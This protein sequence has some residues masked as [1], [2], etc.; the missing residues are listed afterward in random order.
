[1]SKRFAFV[2]AVVVAFIAATAS[3]S[4][5]AP[6]PNRAA[7][8]ATTM[9]AR[10]P[11]NWPQFRG[12][13][14]LGIAEDTGVPTSWSESDNV[15]WKSII[16]GRGHSSPVVWG[17]R[18]FISSAIEG[19]VIPGASAPTHYIGGEVF[20]HPQ[21]MGSDRSH[22]LKVM[23]YSRGSGELLWSE[24]AYQGRM[25]DDRHQGASYASATA[26][27]DGDLVFFYFGS[28][29]V[30][31]Y[32]FDGE[33]VWQADLGDFSYF[34]VGLGTS[35][36]LFEDSLILQIDESNGD[37][38][39]IVGLDKRTGEEAWRT[40]RA[41][42]ASWATP[43][44]L[45]DV[46][47]QPQLLA[48]G[49]QLLIAYD[50]RSGEE[51]W[52]LDGLHNNAIHSPVWDGERVYV[53]AG[54]PRSVIQGIR[55][56]HDDAEVVWEYNKGAAYVASN[57][58]YDGYLY[59]TND[60]GIITCLDAA[61]GDVVYEGGRIP[62]PASMLMSSLLVVDGRIMMS[63][64]E[65]DTFFIATGP[66]FAVEGHNTLDNPILATPAIV[67]DTIYVRGRDHLY[68]IADAG[69]AP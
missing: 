57:V 3:R 25:Y 61:T 16:E 14:G 64:P 4:A 20:K 36:I 21:A 52:Q 48:I 47:G 5:S 38:S 40:P 19:E 54:Y 63:T 32:D 41:V 60:K 18:I 56:G 24:V 27:T 15:L 12:P 67:G 26:A 2:V 59:V 8:G 65:G 44:L 43:L 66:E 45:D 13:G 9:S 29:G 22:T 28:Q 35:P 53:S 10:A 42:E 11:E 30:Y 46:D 51:L 37:G 68:A 55:P 50:P 7:A 58:V 33:P 23:A 39:F 17:D 1:M 34:G 49:N 62:V 69:D 31:A 6:L